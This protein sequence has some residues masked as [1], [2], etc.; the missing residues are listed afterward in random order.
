M[1][2]QTT[3]LNSGSEITIKVDNREF[4]IRGIGSKVN[5]IPGSL[6]IFGKDYT[7]ESEDVIFAGTINGIVVGTT[8]AVGYEKDII[9]ENI[10]KLEI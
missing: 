10:T 5:K 2:R 6:Q 8:F 1:K 3:E 9:V 7:K 4:I